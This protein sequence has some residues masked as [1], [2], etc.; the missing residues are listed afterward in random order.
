MLNVPSLATMSS[1]PYRFLYN[2]SL[3]PKE[4]IV[5]HCLRLGLIRGTPIVDRST[6]SVI[7]WVKFGPNVTIDEACTQDWTSKALSDAGASDLHVPRVFDAYTIDYYGS[8]FGFIA[9]EYV[10]GVDCDSNDVELVAKAVERLISLQ[11][12]PDATLGH[13]GG[14]TASII[15]S[16]FSGWLPNAEYKSDQDFY[17]HI[18]NV[19]VRRCLEGALTNSEL[20]QIFKFLHIN[21]N[22]D[23]SGH[24]LYL[25]PSDFNSGNFRKRTTADGRLVVW[26]F[27][28]RATCFMPQPFIEVAL[29]KPMDPFSRAVANKITYPHPPS[30]DAMPLLS[31]SNSLVQYGSKAVALPPGVSRK[32]KAN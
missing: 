18:R 3:P 6:T 17:A 5:D 11:A 21:F 12:P 22:G 16:F 23:I 13:V 15:H 25:C 14:G 29:R 19:S 9:M 8:P 31:A 20:C 32:G 4:T 28:F 10:E 1:S 2:P 30:N 24:R 27:D 26:A 7:A